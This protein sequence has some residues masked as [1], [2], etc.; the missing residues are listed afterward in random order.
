MLSAAGDI[1]HLLLLLPLGQVSGGVGSCS[2]SAQR[3]RD[4]LE[5]WGRSQHCA[6]RSRR[7]CRGI[8]GGSTP[9]RR[10]I[11]RHGDLSRPLRPLEEEDGRRSWGG[12]PQNEL[13]G[14]WRGALQKELGGVWEGAPQK[15]LGRVGGGTPQKDL[16]GIWGGAPQKELRGF[17]GG[18]PQQT[19]GGI[20]ST[21]ALG[22][23]R[24]GL[25][26]AEQLLSLSLLLHLLQLIEDELVLR[27]HLLPGS[28]LQE[29]PHRV[30]LVPPR[31][32]LGAR[33]H[34]PSPPLLDHVLAAL[35]VQVEAL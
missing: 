19:L 8:C 7:K 23:I 10:C 15:E 12:S 27:L 33:W 18:A 35:G 31:R 26:Q 4:I 5:A 6:L 22:G 1:L 3:G 11:V 32:L 9:C 17:W 14:I 20:W 21:E 24:G 30:G 25:L 13:G 16:G 29:A 2:L 28:P 34:R